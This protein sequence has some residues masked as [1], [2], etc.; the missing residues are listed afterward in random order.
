M[1]FDGLLN[2]RCHSHA[3]NPTIMW[4]HFQFLHIIASFCCAFRMSKNS[5]HFKQMIKLH[6]NHSYLH[7]VHPSR[8]SQLPIFHMSLFYLLISLHYQLQTRLK[9]VWRVGRS[10]HGVDR[11]PLHFMTLSHCKPHIHIHN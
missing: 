7:A 8:A 3:H 1:V 2:F 9:S 5:F 4:R 6:C 11:L 10:H